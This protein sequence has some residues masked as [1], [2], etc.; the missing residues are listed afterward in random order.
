MAE[1]RKRGQNFSLEEKDKLVKILL[2]HKD[3]ILNKKTDRTTNE[4]KNMAWL[5]VTN[6]FNS[7]GTIYRNKESLMKVWE[8]FKSES[9]LYHNN[10]KQNCIK[11]GGG[12]SVIKIDPVLE[13]VCAILGRGCTGILGVSDCDG[14]EESSV[15]FSSL[16]YPRQEIA[17]D[18]SLLKWHGRLSFAQKINSM[19]AQQESMIKKEKS[20]CRQVLSRLLDVTLTLSTCNLAFRGH[21]ENA[22]SIFGG[23][24]I[25][26]LIHNSVSKPILPINR[27]SNW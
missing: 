5:S 7:T 20:F 17:I 8:K 23:S 15:K 22:D 21:R 4:A 2:A 1:K 9:Q 13:Q 24:Y 11:T 19:V 25:N 12:P 26:P 14:D 27:L 10:S 18:E 16:Y 3:T 6:T